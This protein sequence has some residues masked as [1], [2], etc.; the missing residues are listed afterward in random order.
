MARIIDFIKRHKLLWAVNA[1]LLIL[2][3][4]LTVTARNKADELY[5]QQ[6]ASRWENEDVGLPVEEKDNPVEQVKAVVKRK[7][8]PYAQV[9]AFIST[10][11]AM[12]IEEIGSVR[13]SLTEVLVK[14]SYA[15]SETGGR[16]WIDA[17]S[18]ETDINLRKDSNTLSVK[19]VGVGGDFFQF[20]PMRLLSGNYISE[21]DLNH[22]RIVVDE[23]F[24]WAMFGSN[25]IVGMQVWLN[26]N[27]YFIAGV[28]DVDDDDISMMAYGNGNRVYMSY[29]ELKKQQGELP[30]TCYEAVF[31]NPI[32]NYA[33][34][35]LRSA[36][37][38]SD[39]SDEGL[40]K[41]ENPLSFDDVEVIENTKRYE[42]LELIT[43]VKKWR[44]R[45]MR[46]S[47]VGYPFWEN[48]ARVSDD[49]QMVLL[50]IRLLLLICPLITLVWVIYSL[51]EMKTWTVKG[52]ILK[53][54][55][56]A[57]ERR[58]WKA[59][60]AKLAAEDEISDDEFAEAVEDEISKGELAETAEDEISDDEFAEAAED[61]VS[62]GELA[63]TAED[64]VSDDEFAEAVE[65]E[66][67]GEELVEIVKVEFSDEEI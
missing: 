59:Y 14:D 53:E 41:K 25:D 44:L 9:S 2:Y 22:D 51:W 47:S 48:V 63:E 49:E 43:N 64:E 45:S 12:G 17:Y 58:A 4:V 6:E 46:T 40:D 16:V 37:G 54:I 42:T 1:V 61:E 19:A 36:F 30:I 33:Y 60:E 29:D 34:Y 35:A 67:S 24:A 31:P 32:S 15:E 20:H 26:D 39:E 27:I 10:G 38:L 11:H 28:V 13:S 50:I 55:D 5:S 3:I 21:S 8:M 57:R 23:N 62:K 56:N 7:S 18:G 65:D 52:L 66:I